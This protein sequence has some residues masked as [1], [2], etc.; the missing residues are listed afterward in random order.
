MLVILHVFVCG[1]V[2]RDDLKYAEG[3][4]KRFAHLN[5]SALANVLHAKASEPSLARK[6]LNQNAL[7][8]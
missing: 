5:A 4:H 1:S 2:P 7:S 6:L 8:G 3:Q